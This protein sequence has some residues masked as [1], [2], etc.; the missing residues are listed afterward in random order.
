MGT[1]M[2]DT[3]LN[4]LRRATKLNGFFGYHPYTWSKS[5]GGRV[6]FDSKN[7]YK[8]TLFYLHIGLFWTF[9]AFLTI[10]ALYVTFINPGSRSVS[11]R[12]G[13]QFLPAGHSCPLPFQ[14]CSVVLC[15][16][17]HVM[18][19]RY[20][21]FRKDLQVEWNRIRPKKRCKSCGTFMRH[22]FLAGTLNVVS[23]VVPILT[24]P[25]APNVITS[26]VPGVA[27]MPKWQR[28]PFAIV[29]FLIAAHPW[30]LAYLYFTLIIGLISDLENA[31][32]LMR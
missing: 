31:L 19:N 24:K 3:A 14:I 20:L 18:L 21:S 13:L 27:Q 9:E 5:S 25:Q 28:L 23:N 7:V 10:Q 22:L 4:H 8:R 15:D 11:T 32:E 30:V 2:D 16:Q 1:E 29:Q 17:F 26:V 12:V 6:R